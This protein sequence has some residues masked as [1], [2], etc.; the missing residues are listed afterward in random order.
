M[1]I[2]PLIVLAAPVLAAPQNPES[3]A[4]SPL[5]LLVLL[6]LLLL[7]L[8]LYDKRRGFPWLTAVR[9]RIGDLIY[10]LR[11]YRRQKNDKQL[12]IET[13]EVLATPK[14]VHITEIDNERPFI[15]AE[16]NSVLQE[17][18]C[19]SRSDPMAEQEMEEHK[20][21]VDLKRP[22][23]A[24]ESNN[25]KKKPVKSKSKLKSKLQ[26]AEGEGEKQEDLDNSFTEDSSV[27]GNS[28]DAP[29][30]GT[31]VE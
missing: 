2:T 20:Q 9:H 10:R 8:V 3:F 24:R 29:V 14:S 25:K 5:L 1:R 12:R 7:G 11:T 26:F 28:I 13:D 16:G 23:Q 27:D 15:E 30:R 18:I 19:A 4:S 21:E 6:L 22:F 17:S 31:E